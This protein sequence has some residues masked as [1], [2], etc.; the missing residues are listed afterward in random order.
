V[1]VCVSARARS[2]LT[3]RKDNCRSARARKDPRCVGV[4]EE[5]GFIGTFPHLL[6][7]E[8]E[9]IPESAVI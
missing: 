3:A 2:G 4:K 5:R 9:R 8:R 6:R 1:R 7:V